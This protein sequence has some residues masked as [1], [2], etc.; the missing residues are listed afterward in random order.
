[1]NSAR[2]FCG[3]AWCLFWIVGCGGTSER[4]SGPTDG[5]LDAQ[6]EP[7]VN[8]ASVCASVCAELSTGNCGFILEECPLSCFYSW[9]HCYTWPAALSCFEQ[10]E[11]LSCIGA[12]MPCQKQVDALVECE[13]TADSGALES[14]IPG[15]VIPK[16]E[17]DGSPS[18]AY[19][20]PESGKY[21]PC[22]C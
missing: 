21:V 20:C 12:E 7:D 19:V 4:N 15:E 18:S 10:H 14:C 5:G 8:T 13:K 16:C 2:V 22:A 6:S 9:Q 11:V 17:C 3:A 1:M